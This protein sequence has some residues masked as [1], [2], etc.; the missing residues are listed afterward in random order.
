VISLKKTRKTRS[1]QNFSKKTRFVAKTHKTQVLCEI[2]VSGHFF[3]KL[4]KIS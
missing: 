2:Y 4:S 3:A 1:T